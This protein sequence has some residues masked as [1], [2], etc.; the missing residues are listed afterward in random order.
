MPNKRLAADVKPNDEVSEIKIKPTWL[1][2]LNF[3]GKSNVIW[4][5]KS[6]PGQYENMSWINQLKYSPPVKIRVDVYAILE[7]MLLKISKNSTQSKVLKWWSLAFVYR[8]VCKRS[9]FF[10]FII[11]NYSNL[12]SYKNVKKPFFGWHHIFMGVYSAKFPHSSCPL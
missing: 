9:D 6:F 1:I 12:L 8:K 5:Y 2:F 3:K 11:N 7:L 4:D 10:T